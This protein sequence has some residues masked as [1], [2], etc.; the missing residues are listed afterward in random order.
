MPVAPSDPD[1]NLPKPEYSPY[2]INA[3]R[4]RPGTMLA[5]SRSVKV[6]R[7]KRRRICLR[8]NRKKFNQTLSS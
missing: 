6:S 5:S 7:V 2:H 4:P 8:Q 1:L 3:T